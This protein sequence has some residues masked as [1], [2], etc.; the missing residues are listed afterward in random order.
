MINK[1][2]KSL[3]CVYIDILRMMLYPLASLVILALCEFGI[4]EDT[5]GLIAVCVLGIMFIFYGVYKIYWGIKNFITSVS[6]AKAGD[7]D[8]LRAFMKTAKFGSIP[9]YIIVFTINLITW[10]FFIIATR[11]LVIFS[12]PFMIAPAVFFTYLNVIF[13]SVFSICFLIDKKSK[14]EISA[15]FMVI[16]ILLQL[17]FVT[18][19]IDT[20]YLCIKFKK[21]KIEV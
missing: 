4:N 13:T 11:G 8:R 21:N 10:A 7:S 18:D 3:N 15:A 14:G 6:L 9:M 19:V 5:A 12:F 16:N 20:I 2:R 1:K 17:C